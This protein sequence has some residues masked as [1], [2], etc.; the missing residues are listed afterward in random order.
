M[1]FSKHKFYENRPFVHLLLTFPTFSPGF[2]FP[3]PSDVVLPPLRKLTAGD[4]SSP[5]RRNLPSTF[6]SS[7][8]ISNPNQS[9]QVRSEALS[10]NSETAFWKPRAAHAPLLSRLG[11]ELG[12]LSPPPAAAPGPGRTAK[13]RGQPG[14]ETGIGKERG[15]PSPRRRSRGGRRRTPSTET[16]QDTFLRPPRPGQECGR[17]SQARLKHPGAAHKPAA[18]GGREWWFG[19]D[20]ASRR[21][22]EESKA[23]R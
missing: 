13:Q 7:W 14:G 12:A 21:R 16:C 8:L 19:A 3:R 5:R 10:R 6:G 11:L 18:W 9:A 23:G 22:L 2:H 17:G 20:E 15:S 1:R 4:A